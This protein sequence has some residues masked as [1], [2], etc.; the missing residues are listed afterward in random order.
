M[1]KAASTGCFRGVA[2][3]WEITGNDYEFNTIFKSAERY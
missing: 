3:Q 2:L 1:P